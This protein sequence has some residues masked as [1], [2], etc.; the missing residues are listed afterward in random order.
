MYV[1]IDGKGRCGIL[2]ACNACTVTFC[3]SFVLVSWRGKVLLFIV[4]GVHFLYVL[5]VLLCQDLF[6]TLR[7][8][9]CIVLCYVCFVPQGCV[10]FVYVLYLCTCACMSL[11]DVMRCDVLFA[12]V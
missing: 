12:C 3:F 1:C 8:M 11:C 10:L 7:Y 5:T 4:I 9:C 2:M 6:G